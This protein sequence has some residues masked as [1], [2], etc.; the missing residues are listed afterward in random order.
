MLID[1]TKG[2]QYL[3]EIKDSVVAG[4]QWATKEVQWQ[5]F[6][7]MVGYYCTFSRVYCVK[8]MLEGFGSTFMMLH[9]TRMPSIV[10]EAK[11]YQPPDVFC[12]LVC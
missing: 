3:N 6:I 5:A 8:K 2:V 10:E 4:F 11:L 12:M 1:C 7:R 9:Y